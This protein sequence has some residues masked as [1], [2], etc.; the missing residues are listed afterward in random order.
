MKIVFVMSSMLILV[1]CGAWERTKANYTGYS[2]Q[3]VD[4]VTYIQFPSGVTV[5]VD[6]TGK[7]VPCKD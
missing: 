6:R 7:P 1:G 3:C 5:H 4:G 2:K